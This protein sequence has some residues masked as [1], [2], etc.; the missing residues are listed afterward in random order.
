MEAN[1]E[2]TVSVAKATV[3]SLLLVGLMWTTSS[4]Y[5]SMNQQFAEIDQ[6]FAEAREER[7]RI[8]SDIADLRERTARV[9]TKVDNLERRMGQMES[10]LE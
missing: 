5:V 10:A 1:L 9:E 4:M 2:T 3:P 6:R 8:Q 7:A